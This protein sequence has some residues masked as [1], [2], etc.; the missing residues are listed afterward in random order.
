MN[1]TVLQPML[2]GEKL[3]EKL[4]VLPAYDKRICRADAVERLLGLSS[5]Y[6]IYIPSAMSTEIYSKLYLAMLR[7]IQKKNSK[8]AVRQYYENH[9]QAHCGESRGIIGGSDSFTV[10]GTSGIGKSSAIAR[11]VTLASGA[12]QQDG[13]VP[14]I[15]CQCPHD[16]SVKGLLLEILRRVDEVLGSSYYGQAVRSRATSDM[17]VGSVS[18][19]ALNH[20]G[21]LIV[22]EIQNARVNRKGRNLVSMLVQLIN[23]SGISIA[24]V[25]TPECIPFFEQEMQMAR[26]ALGL[27]YSALPYGE[28]FLS[29]CK[30]VS[31]YQYVRNACGFREDMALWLYEHSGGIVSLVVSLLHDAQEIAILDGTECLDRRALQKAYDQRYQM[32]A[33]YVEAKKGKNSPPRSRPAVQVPAGQE[34]GCLGQDGFSVYDTAMESRKTGKDCVRELEKHITVEE[35]II[36]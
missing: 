13:I 19:I 33:G 35:V 12:G 30:A 6:D 26:R 4:T 5:L 31:G 8:E 3:R 9:K 10:I 15:I 21:L 28:E 17:L 7:S 32:M 27:Y 14:C 11:A 23:N 2:A 1:E 22:D 29:F 25:G 20:I 16:C 34:E 24:M 18:T 36:P